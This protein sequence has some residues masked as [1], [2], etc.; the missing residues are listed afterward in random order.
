MSI[1]LGFSSGSPLS[2]GAGLGFVDRLPAQNLRNKGVVRSKSAK[3]IHFAGNF[4]YLAFNKAIGLQ[5]KIYFEISSQMEGCKT[6]FQTPRPRLPHNL[7]SLD[8]QQQTRAIIYYAAY[9]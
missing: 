7:R 1:D 8:S 3:K 2:G 5:K 4:G 6:N 9:R